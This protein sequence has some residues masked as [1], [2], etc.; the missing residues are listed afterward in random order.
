MST[1]LEIKAAI[2][3]LTPHERCELEAMLHPWP[4][5]S[6]DEQMEGDAEAGGKLFKLVETSKRA[7]QAGS[8]RD[9]PAP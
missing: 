8:L 5:D 7:S 4:N 6:W 9:F 3:Q 2:D 1:V